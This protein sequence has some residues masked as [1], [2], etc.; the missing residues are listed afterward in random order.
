MITIFFKI[1]T[2]SSMLT[3]DLKV[4]S[5]KNLNFLI[6]KYCNTIFSIIPGLSLNIPNKL[7][8]LKIFKLLKFFKHVFS[9]KKQ[10]LAYW[11]FNCILRIFVLP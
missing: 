3:N 8:T 7:A 4:P 11:S 6:P 9:A 1:F 5:L 2:K 10:F